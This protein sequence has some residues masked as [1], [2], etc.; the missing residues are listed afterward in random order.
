MIEYLFASGHA[1][2]IVI[3]VLA[4]E[5]LWLRRRDWSWVKVARVLGPAIFIILAVRAALVGAPWY[6]VAGALAASLPL[7]LLDLRARLG[8]QPD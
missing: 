7:H 8:S 2:D 6:W 5:G 4:L 3:A 1:A